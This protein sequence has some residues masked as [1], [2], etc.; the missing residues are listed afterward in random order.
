MNVTNNPLIYDPFTTETHMSYT[1]N[2]REQNR[3][4]I[5]HLEHVT[6]QYQ[7]PDTCFSVTGSL[8]RLEKGALS[9]IELMV[10]GDSKKAADYVRTIGLSGNVGKGITVIKPSKKIP[11]N[12]LIPQEIKFDYKALHSH[13]L[14]SVSVARDMYVDKFLGRIHGPYGEIVNHVAGVALDEARKITLTGISSQ[15]AVHFLP[16]EGVA[17]YHSSSRKALPSQRSFYDGPLKLVRFRLFKDMVDAI[18]E[19]HDN[20]PMVSYFPLNT[21]DRLVF[22]KEMGLTQYSE[23]K[24][25]DI[26]ENYAYFLRMYHASQWNFEKYKDST[27]DVNPKELKQRLKDLDVLTR[28]KILTF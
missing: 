14:S 27:L 16:P 1:M 8:A 26:A 6:Q 18:R 23:G 24:L 28:N 19:D 10:I 3:K 9:R 13:P 21:F 25:I 4:I 15:G 20:V 2:L 17:F 12:G 7:D 11:T 22:A 5:S